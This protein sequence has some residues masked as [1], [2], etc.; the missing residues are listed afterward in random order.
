MRVQWDAVW[1]GAANGLVAG[2]VLAVLVLLFVTVMYSWPLW[3]ILV[4]VFLAGV[5]VGADLE[6]L[7]LRR[8]RNRRAGVDPGAPPGGHRVEPAPAACN[9]P[10]LAR[11]FVQDAAP[12]VVLQTPLADALC[13][14]HRYDQPVDMPIGPGLARNHGRGLDVQAVV[15][16]GRVWWLASRRAMS[17]Y[18]GDHQEW[19]LSA[20]GARGAYTYMHHRAVLCQSVRPTVEQG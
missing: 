6:R 20:P 13:R 15:Q 19:T 8:L 2:V 11:R 12:G 16:Y 7:V 5:L 1:M 3:A 14:P 17:R 4:A 9:V 10:E 18:A